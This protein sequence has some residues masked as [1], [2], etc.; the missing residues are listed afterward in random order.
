[1]YAHKITR[2]EINELDTRKFEGRI[3]VIDTKSKLRDA[4]Q[5]IN[6]RSMLGFDTESRPSFK[7]GLIHEVSLFQFADSFDA[8]LIRVNRVGL[9]TGLKEVLQNGDLIKIGAGL[10]DDMKRIRELDSIN[11]DGF[12]DLQRFVENYDIESKSLKKMTAIILGFKISKSQQLSNWNAD[13]YSDAQK[14]Y[15]ATDAWV[16]HEMYRKLTAGD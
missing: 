7:K 15:A 14:V 6:K 1:M 8:W 9:S 2:E 16:C 13:E 5:E 11:P 4:L 3:H 10:N 12:I